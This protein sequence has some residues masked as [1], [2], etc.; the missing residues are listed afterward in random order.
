[1]S[2]TVTVG[3]QYKAVKRGCVTVRVRDR[4][5]L[6][7]QLHALLKRTPGL[8]RRRMADELHAGLDAVEDALG[9]L[10]RDGRAWKYH[11]R[12]A[13]NRLDEYWCAVG[14]TATDHT[15]RFGAA[16]TLAGFRALVRTVGFGVR[17]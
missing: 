16:E 9:M 13:R 17:P 11:S 14:H 1:M 5:A 3:I 12:A 6:A 8:A 10:E 4:N 2:T 15:S 7:D